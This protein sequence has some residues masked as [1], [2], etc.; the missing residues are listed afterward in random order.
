MSSTAIRDTMS[1]APET[2]AVMRQSADNALPGTSDVPSYTSFDDMGLSDEILRGIYTLGYQ[3]PSPIQQKAIVPMM[4]RRDIIAQAQSGT[5]KT[6]T[7]S[8]GSIQ[9]VDPSI[10]APQVLV[11]APT[12]E[13]AQ[14]SYTTAL[15]IGRYIDLQ[16]LCATGGPPIAEDMRAL[17]RGAQFIVGTPGRVYDLIRRGAL[18]LDN[19]RVL[20]MDEAD[21]MLED[22]FREQVLCILEFKFPAATRIAFFSATMPPEVTEVAER[23]LDNPCRILI[24][25]EAVTLEGIKQYYMMVEQENYKFDVLLDIL[26]NMSI[27]QLIIFVNKRQKAEGLSEAMRDN[28]F[29]IECIHGEM[30]VAERK[31][32]MHDFRTG[33]ARILIAT[34]LLARGIDVQQVS[35]VINYE[36][37]LQRE[38]YIHRIGRSGRYGRKGVAINLIVDEEGRTLEEYEQYYSTKINPLPEDLSSITSI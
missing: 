23:F 35:T 33:K 31:K 24:P 27:A 8:I 20:I 1:T 10:K 22:R 6:A 38:N 18:K 9:Q 7:F 29:T 19:I 13:L 32:R 16:V 17:Q 21:Q 11:L 5:G 12:R 25:P 36:L 15:G 4:S 26:R 28:N 37:P 2:N 30:D 3:N 14:Q 34:D